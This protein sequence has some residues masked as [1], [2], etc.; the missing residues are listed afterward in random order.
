MVLSG[1][2][3]HVDAHFSDV[4]RL[5]ADTMNL[6]GFEMHQLYAGSMSFTPEFWEANRHRVLGPDGAWKHLNGKPEL[7]ARL[8]HASRTHDAIGRL[9]EI[10]AP[11]L[12]LARRAGHLDPAPANPGHRGR[13]SGRDRGVMERYGPPARTAGSK[14]P[15]QRSGGRLPRRR[16]P[17]GLTADR[18]LRLFGL[19]SLRPKTL[20]AAH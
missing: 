6:G 20:T 7:V 4:L 13:H 12:V 14:A 2:W 17:S 10:T 16:S 18:S 5:L 1:C 9:P 15:L 11:T 19:A 8:V 3:A